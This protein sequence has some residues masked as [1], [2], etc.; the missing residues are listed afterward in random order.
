MTKLRTA[1]ED[2]LEAATSAIAAGDWKVDG[3]CDPTSAIAAMR[4]ALKTEHALD[5]MM[6]IGQEIG[7]D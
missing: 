7:Y 5:E 6:R 2:L 3:A 4:H 1:A